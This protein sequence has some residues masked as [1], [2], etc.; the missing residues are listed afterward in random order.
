M[1][2]TNIISTIGCRVINKPIIISERTCYDFLK[3]RAWVILR[4]LVYRFSNA[5][6][7]Q[8]NYDKKKYNRLSNIFVIDN[9][10]NLEEMIP[11]N[12]REENNII[13]VGRLDRVKGF[14]RLIRAFARLENKDWKLTIVGEGS[15][16]NILEKL[17]YDLK[18]EDYISMPGRTKAIEKWYQKSSIFVLSS[19]IEGFGNVLCEAMAYGC[20][21]VSFDC[22]AGPNEIITDKIDGYLVKDGDINALSEKMDFLINNPEDRRRIGR[23]AMKIRDRL[24]IDSIMSKWDKIIEKILKVH[25]RDRKER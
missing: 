18:L 24:N 12:D 5:L 2:E 10:L 14:D 22:I 23:E 9:P 11:N 16:R 4:K 21:C 6:V 25:R 1:T 20:A 19:R 13:A 8:T 15:E 7:V 3:S 17:I